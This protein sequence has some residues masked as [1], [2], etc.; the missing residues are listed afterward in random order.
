MTGTRTTARLTEW[1]TQ[2]PKGHGG[3]FAELIVPAVKGT[4][5]ADASKIRN[6]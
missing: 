5:A 4:V 6:P 1:A 3:S 2:N